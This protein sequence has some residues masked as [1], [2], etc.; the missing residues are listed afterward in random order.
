MRNLKVIVFIC[1]VLSS[2]AATQAQENGK[3][4]NFK[5]GVETGIDSF[6]GSSMGSDRIRK[7]HDSYYD[8]QCGIHFPDQTLDISYIGAKAEYF[9]WNNRIGMA[10][11][12]RVSRYT[13]TLTSD[14]EYF[15]WLLR[16]DQLTTDYVKIRN[17]AKNSYYIGVPLEF[18]FFPNNHDWFFQ[19]YIKLGAVFNYRFLTNN[20]VKF[21]DKAMNHHSETVDK[22]IDNP[23]NFNAYIYPAIGFKLARCPWLNVEVHFPCEMFNPKGSTYFRTDAGIGVQFSVQLPLGKTHKMGTE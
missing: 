4:N 21:Q 9:V 16:Q 14:K 6:W 19:H 15:L 8:F 17:I 7:S 3:T 22:Q 12:L 1:F 11:G 5:I 13:S 2:F 23:K 20:N 10:S 18:R